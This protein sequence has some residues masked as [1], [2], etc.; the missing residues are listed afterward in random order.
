VRY[1]AVASKLKVSDRHIY[2][3]LCLKWFEAYLRIERRLEQ[4]LGRMVAIKEVPVEKGVRAAA[5]FVREVMNAGDGPI[6]SIVE[7]L[8]AFGIRAMEIPTDLPIWALAAKLGDEHVVALNP[9]ASPDRCRLSAGH[10]LGHILFGDCAGGG[11]EDEKAM[12]ARA[13][14]FG[15]LLLMPPG[16][17]KKFC[18]PRS[19]VTLVQAKEQYGISLSAMIY[20]AQREKMLPATV[21][22][23]LWIEFSKRGWRENEP[24]KVRADRALRFEQLVDGAMFAGRLTVGEAAE[25][26]GVREEEMRERLSLALG[27]QEYS[28]SAHQKDDAN[29]DGEFQ[30]RLAE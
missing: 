3:G 15:S 26:A 11:G 29:A 2:E 10:E 23:R 19:M 22:K 25:I 9:K 28:A 12:E 6:W 24:G 17:L 21:C 13:Y 16:V 14:E 20:A 27:I 30:L 8:H 1:R 18:E 7:V 5:A 4:P